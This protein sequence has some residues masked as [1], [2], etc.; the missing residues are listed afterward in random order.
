MLRLTGS[1]QRLDEQDGPH[2]HKPQ[3][4]HSPADTLIQDI[5]LQSCGRI[6]FLLF[7]VICWLARNPAWS[8][9]P[10]ALT[11][12]RSVPGLHLLSA[13]HFS[14]AYHKVKFLPRCPRMSVV[15]PIPTWAESI[16]FQQP[17]YPDKLGCWLRQTRSFMGCTPSFK[18]SFIV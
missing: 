17:H 6:N 7:V 15:S 11:L 10:S 12:P 4:D 3:R 9:T 18:Y 16:A 5:C 2:L 8:L 1:H 14:S 13:W